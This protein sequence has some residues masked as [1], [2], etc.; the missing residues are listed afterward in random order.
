MSENIIRHGSIMQ[1]EVE[2]GITPPDIVEQMT[3]KH[4]APMQENEN[5]QPGGNAGG[6]VQWFSLCNEPGESVVPLYRGICD[7]PEPDADTVPVSEVLEAF[8][9]GTVRIYYAPSDC[10][11][12]M[13]GHF[14]RRSD[15]NVRI[16]L[17]VGP[18]EALIAIIGPAGTDTV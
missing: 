7:T 11:G 6:G 13:T 10:Y 5:Y 14:V 9:S 4:S 15:K 2:G 12:T 8:K 3:I 17:S 16:G 18:S 1:D